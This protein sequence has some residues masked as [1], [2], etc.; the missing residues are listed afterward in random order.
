MLKFLT[1]LQSV[2]TILLMSSL[3][4]AHADGESAVWENFKAQGAINNNLPDFSYAGFFLRDIYSSRDNTKTF[5]V[6]DFGAIPNDGIDD[7]LA[8]QLAIDEASNNGGGIVFIPKGMYRIKGGTKEHTLTIKSSNIT[9]KGEAAE[10][11]NASV[12]FLENPS[13]SKTLGLLGKSKDDMRS[14]ATLA[15]EGEDD[16]SI[17]ALFENQDLLRG[18]RIVPVND[19]SKL[20][21]NQTIRIQLTEPLVDI[22]NPNKENID[23]IKLL[24][25]PFEFTGQETKTFGRY[26][27]V[28]EYITKI[29]RIVDDNHIEL[30]QAL[31]FDHLSRY[32]PTIVAFNGISNIGVQNIKFESAW[33]GQFV[34][35]QAYPNNDVDESDIIR[36]EAE[37]DYGWVAIWGTWLAD[38]SIKNVVFDNYTQNIIL[39]NTA[40]VN[41]ENIL[42]TGK[43]GHAG[44][45]Y[46]SAYSILTKGITFEGRY[47]HPVSIRA[48]A[49]GCVFSDMK[50]LDSTY[51]DADRTGPFIDFHG[52]YPYENLFE[53]MQGFYAH[54]GGDLDVLPHSGVRNTLWNVE[55][56]AV[57]DRFSYSRNEFFSTTATS[58]NKMYQYYPSTFVVGVYGK[59]ELEVKINKSTEDR[60]DDFTIIES[61]NS[62]DIPFKSLYQQQVE[63]RETQYPLPPKPPVLL[64]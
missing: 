22:D 46:S 11:E 23:L 39:S 3:C 47:A 64:D 16:K 58:A 2:C 13:S 17:L 31:R 12:L 28:V 5:N 51:N 27:N 19:T 26:G 50:V 10:G 62:R 41:V 56:P 33:E 7:S 29:R 4:T 63:L 21:A 55:T 34:H 42:L 61:L 48:W 37:Q 14:I 53:N 30:F 44:L 8:I 52:L 1:P 15:I 40:F 45:T 43:G 9:L 36:S 32:S 57:I 49:S 35:H 24:T 20:S 60:V 25:T 18:T 38:S 59:D 54:S 6:A